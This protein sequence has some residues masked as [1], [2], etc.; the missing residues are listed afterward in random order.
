MAFEVIP[1]QTYR[2]ISKKFLWR[3]LLSTLILSNIL[4]LDF[5]VRT[6]CFFCKIS[7]N[8][9][10]EHLVVPKFSLEVP[11]FKENVLICVITVI[12][13]RDLLLTHSISDIEVI[14]NRRDLQQD[15]FGLNTMYK[16]EIKNT[17]KVTCYITKGSLNAGKSHIFTL[18]PQ[19][20]S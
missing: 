9:S 4:I 3:S 1:S 2:W 14:S 7:K 18:P 10:R 6:Q 16:N 8:L 11:K 5:E 15:V 17:P 13:L 19:N 12:K 20:K